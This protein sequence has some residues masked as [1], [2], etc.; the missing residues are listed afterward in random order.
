MS[1]TFKVKKSDREPI[2]FNI[3]FERDDD[4]TVTEKFRAVPVIPGSTVLDL[5]ASGSL[6]SAYQAAALRGFYSRA[7][8][9]EDRERFFKTLDESDPAIDLTQLSEI[10]N[11]LV[12]EYGERPTSSAEPS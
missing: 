9:D 11:W 3:E 4:E 12:A 7:L 10:A 5:V 1:K 8:V 2:E 6:E